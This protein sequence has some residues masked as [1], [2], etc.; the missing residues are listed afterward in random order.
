MEISKKYLELKYNSMSNDDL[1][2]E[3]GISYPTLMKLIDEAGIQRKGSGN[4]YYNDK[5]KV[6]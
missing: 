3:L 2:K 6:V 5:I 1:C 4:K